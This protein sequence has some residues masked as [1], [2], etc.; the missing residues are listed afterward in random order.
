M[1]EVFMTKR[2][3]DN[4]IDLMLITFCVIVT[5]YGVTMLQQ[6]SAMKV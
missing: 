4:F 2:L 3:T 6:I 5:I 1:K